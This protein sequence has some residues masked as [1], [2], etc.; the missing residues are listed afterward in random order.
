MSRQSSRKLK[1]AVAC[2]LIAL[3]GA[4]VGAWSYQAEN[5]RLRRALLEDARRSTIAFDMPEIGR[6]AASRTDLGTPEYAAVKERLQRLKTIDARVRFVY[7]FRVRPES[8]RVVFIADSAQAGAKDESLPGDDYPEAPNSPG[9]QEIIRTGQPSTEGP[10]ADAFGTWITAYATLG[11]ARPAGRPDILGIDVDAAGWRR[12]L[13][14]SALQGT[15]FVWIVL[16]LPLVAWFFARRQIEQGYVIRNLS[17]AVEQS[18]SAILI[19]GLDNRIEFANRGLCEQIGYTRAELIGRSWQDF[20]VTETG[21]EVLS[22]LISTV[23]S[24]RPWEGEWFNKRQ[25]GSVYP[26]HGVV[27]PVKNHDGSLA[28]FV[29]IFDDVTETKH[30]EAE[31][32]EARD[33]AQAGDRAKGHFLATMSHEVRTPL[34]GIVGFTSLLLDTPLTPEQRE[35]VQTIRL[36][37]EALIQLTGDI[38]DFAR[39]ESGKLKLDPVACDPRECVEA[40][41]DMLAPKAD[42]KKIELLHR[43]ADDVPGAVV[44]DS[45]RLRQVLANLIGNAVKFTENGE[46]EVSVR[47][48]P[49]EGEG[50]TGSAAAETCLLEFAVRD[51]GIG[52]AP[53][54]HGKLFRAFT[55][56]DESTTRRYGGTGLGL[57]ICRNLVELMGGTIGLQSEPG[58]GATFTFTIRALVAGP[59]HAPRDL[60]GLRLGLAISQ[61]ALRGELAALVRR[62]GGEVVEVDHPSLL[63]KETVDIVLVEAGEE[64][65]NDATI[66]SALEAVEPDKRLGL[67]PITLSNELRS[68]LRSYFRLLINKPVHHDAFLGLLA[69]SVGGVPAPPMPPFHYGYRVLVAEDNAVNQRLVH[70]VLINLGC[71]PTAAENGRRV[72]EVLRQHADAFDFV[73]LDLHLPEIDGISALRNIRSG[74]AGPAAQGIWIIALTADVREE[75]RVRSMAEGLNDYLTKPLRPTDLESALKRFRAHRATHTPKM[76]G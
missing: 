65:I 32:R 35:Y 43:V 37:T 12:E 10:L 71:K 54:H 31:M 27:T 55:Q 1:V 56:V 14:E 52:I 48:L 61:R 7:L 53:E 69:G 41:L 6:L 40:A 30:R 4:A 24:G 63:K 47:R 18:H 68:S 76:E 2:A 73:L 36:S 29:A 33:R 44:T 74:R 25:N 59:A 42:P 58:S 8:G 46:V 23:K 13:W 19:I 38:L 9:L 67:I 15:F 72:L 39:I 21:E 3:V 34:N 20:R 66:P 70:R 64:T 22:D 75:Q 49:F 11:D 62:S 57:A 5:A 16:G 60:G 50:P 17:Q 51:T 28:C 26:V 45:G